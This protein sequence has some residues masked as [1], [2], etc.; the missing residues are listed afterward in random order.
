ML[1]LS[2]SEKAQKQYQKKI[3]RIAL[4][5]STSN[6]FTKIIIKKYQLNTYTKI[7]TEIQV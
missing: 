6:L 1:Q 7:T 5:N 3:K 2:Y 4:L